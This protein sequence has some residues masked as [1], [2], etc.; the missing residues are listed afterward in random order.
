MV[1]KQKVILFGIGLL[2]TLVLLSLSGCKIGI[3][4]GPVPPL[5]S[6]DFAVTIDPASG[7]PPLRVIVS[8]TNMGSGTYT[9][10]ATGKSTVQSTENTLSMIVGTWPWVCAVTWEDGLGGFEVQSA[11]LALENTAPTIYWPRVN[12]RDPQYDNYVLHEV[13]RTVF[14][15]NFF[16]TTS[17]WP[18][19]IARRFGVL[20]SEGDE[21]KIINVEVF[22]HGKGFPGGRVVTVYTPPYEPGVY[23]TTREIGRGEILPNSFLLYPPYKAKWD[24]LAEQWTCITPERGYRPLCLKEGVGIPTSPTALL[25]VWVQ[26]EDKLGARSERTFDFSLSATGCNL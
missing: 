25:T 12:G 19:D 5:P 22:W 20:D 1:K 11:S 15:F 2:L 7:H 17:F 6:G 13:E 3:G 18:G 16:E 21:W 26:V 10:E 24:A 23:H 9:Y 8:A 4:V 14:D